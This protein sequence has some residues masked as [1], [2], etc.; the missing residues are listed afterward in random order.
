MKPTKNN[1]VPNQQE[2][3]PGML[4]CGGSKTGKRN[5]KPEDDGHD[6]VTTCIDEYRPITCDSLKLVQIQIVFRHGARTPLNFI[7]GLEEATY[8]ASLEDD[9]PETDFELHV[10]KFADGTP[11]GKS[12]MEPDLRARKLKGGAHA[13]MLTTVGQ[14]QMYDL[15]LIVREFYLPELEL[16]YFS[17]RDVFIRSS[18]IERTIK[19]M[20][21]LLA[22]MF[23]KENINK[24]GPVKLPVKHMFE[25]DIFPNKLA[26]PALRL[27][28]DMTLATI[29]GL[30]GFKQDRYTLC[31][32]LG[33][34]TNSDM[35]FACLR[36]DIVSRITHGAD[37]PAPLVPYKKMIEDNAARTIHA[38][39]AGRAGA[40]GRHDVTRLSIG[41]L[42]YTILFNIENRAE[43]KMSQKVFLYSGHDTTLAPM[44]VALG[45]WDFRWP[46]FAANIIYELYK[47]SDTS[48][49]FV[50]VLYCG[51]PK[52]IGQPPR[53]LVP[54]DE[55]R[56][57]IHPY[58]IMPGEY[59]QACTLQNLE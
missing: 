27:I 20:K 33:I 54:L 10:V 8:D 19:S 32:A 53:I 22:G 39:Y 21:C 24:Y 15:G 52:K 57:S 18:H 29:D 7:R 36:D 31:K 16:K 11:A 45:I 13:S 6:T 14:R 9:L 49:Y 30:P 26:C 42:L 38:V 44:L 40:R 25:E 23:G 35:D 56:R 37:Y 12:V 3:A 2:I 48:E 34:P 43:D 47:Q 51:E 55:F 4:C 50:R 58:L 17:P 46:P 59:V 28:V 5:R 41:Q 1:K